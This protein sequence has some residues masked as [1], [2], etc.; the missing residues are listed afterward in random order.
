VGAIA[1]VRPTLELK[2]QLRAGGGRT[3]G[4]MLK[5]KIRGDFAS[6]ASRA[7]VRRRRLQ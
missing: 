4:S 2:L 1:L 3:R 7:C 6:F 5:E